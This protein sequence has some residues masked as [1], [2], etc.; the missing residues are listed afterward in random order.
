MR[1]PRATAVGRTP[2]WH[3]TPEFRLR[4]AFIVLAMVMS[5]FAAQLF[6]I[7]GI[8][9]QAYAL[10]AE[11]EGLVTATLPA[12]R[13][14]ITDRNGV[15]LAQSAS[16]L[17]IVADPMMARPYAQPIAQL[18]SQHLNVD[19]VTTLERLQRSVD[20][21]GRDIRFAYLARK[22]PKATAQKI[23]QAVRDAGLAGV[24]TKRDPI[25]DYPG[26]DIAANLIGFAKVPDDPAS[27]SGLE[28]AFDRYL[29]G[30][31]GQETYISQRG[32]KLPLMPSSK[33]DAIDGKRL[34]LTI[35]RDLQWYSQRVL[36]QAVDEANAESGTAVVMD[37]RTGELLALADYPSFDAN[38]PGAA[39]AADRGARSL[40]NIYEPGSVQKILTVA[41]AIDAGKVTPRTKI[42][43]PDSLRIDGWTVGDYFRHPDLRLTLAGVI[44]KSSNVGTVL[45]ARRM[46]HYE[47]RDY[48]SSFGLGARTNIGVAGE[49]RGI[50]PGLERWTDLTHATVSFGQGVSVNSVQMAAAVNTIANHGE[51]VSPSLIKGRATSDDGAVVGTE[52][53]QRH[54]VVSPQAAR[55]TARMMEMVTAEG[56]GTAPRV[57]IPGYRI[58]GKTG[59]AQQ[60]GKACQCY[61]GSISVAF[62]GF[63]PAD[64]PR[65]TVYVTLSKPNRGASGGGTAGPVFTKI[66]AYALQNYGVPPTGRKPAQLP[67]EW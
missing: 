1:I 28:R 44:A 50:L 40:S 30:H 5:V 16:G 25:R 10:R 26:Q 19:Y 46:Q 18:L 67:I 32:T 35:D 45:A 42:T 36:R 58:A 51:Y 15:A 12:E 60:V 11:N 8:D 9:P 48:L 27:G 38:Q 63:A 57:A 34:Q 20:A 52:V 54:Q 53:T 61:D 13:G 31:D 55:K 47:L 39:N 2:R 59:T 6:I 49:A 56:V 43:V 22:V 14:E 4:T 23:M 21:E 37:S 24:F 62:G 17:M 29:S 33:T 7:Q 64:D 41:A 66:M 3:E 65:F